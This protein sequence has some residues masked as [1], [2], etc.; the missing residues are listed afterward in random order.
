M[1]M[2]DG[3]GPDTSKAINDLVK[4]RIAAI[5]NDRSDGSAVYMHFRAFLDSFSDSYNATWNA[6]NYVGRGDTL[7][8]Y[9]GFGR[10]I[11]LS[12]TTAAQS[13]QNLYQCIKN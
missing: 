1:P 7:Y 10:T 12:F 2:Y 9:G 8:N 5:N 6:V 13:K 3:T 4:F 11:S